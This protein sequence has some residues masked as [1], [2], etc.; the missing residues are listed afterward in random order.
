MDLEFPEFNIF[1]QDFH[2]IHKSYEISLINH[3][4]DLGLLQDNF[5]KNKDIHRIL[6]HFTIKETIDFINNKQYTSKPVVYFCNTQFYDSP[7]LEFVDEQDYLHILTNILLRM[8]LLLPI[9]IV[10][11]YKSLEFFKELI[12]RGDGRANGTLL[13]IK[14]A[15]D[16]F[17]IERFTF[18]K[19]KKYAKNNGLTFL[20]GEYFNDIKTKQ[21]VFH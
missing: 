6:I 1:L 20:S 10:I 3:L 2:E 17:N 7:I 11:S 16:K 21:I 8:R 13:K 5:T 4:H 18:E 14:S 12:T 19:I 15:V 9:K